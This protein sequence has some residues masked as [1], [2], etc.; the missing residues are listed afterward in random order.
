MVMKFLPFIVLEDGT[1]NEYGLKSLELP[2]EFITKSVDESDCINDYGGWYHTP[3]EPDEPVTN[4]QDQ[5][6]AWAIKKYD[7]QPIPGKVNCY[8]SRAYYECSDH[9]A[10]CMTNPGFFEVIRFNGN[11]VDAITC[12][13]NDPCQQ[14]DERNIYLYIKGWKYVIRMGRTAEADRKYAE[15]VA[16]GSIWT[17]N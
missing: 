11:L 7:L 8:P 17:G 6:N 14:G 15:G 10:D 12:M 4:S 2:I 9:G 13:A 16:D 5:I 3:P 1:F